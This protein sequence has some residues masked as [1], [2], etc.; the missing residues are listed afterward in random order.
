MNP[1]TGDQL[2][3]IIRESALAI[4]ALLGAIGALLAVM[5]RTRLEAEQTRA[6]IAS[7][8]AGLVTNH[9]STSPGNAIDRL[10]EASER[11]EA[12]IAALAEDVAASRQSIGGL[13]DDVT[14]SRRSIGGLRD[15][16]REMR[17]ETTGRLDGVDGRIEGV[18]ARVSGHELSCPARIPLQRAIHHPP[19]PADH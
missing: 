6:E 17:R 5:V 12:A 10:T 1:I 16:V 13:S 14:A 8:R 19:N 3:D 7:M 11:Q 4:A 18:E 2:P 9:G 15:D